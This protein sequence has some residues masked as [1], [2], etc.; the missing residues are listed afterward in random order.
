MSDSYHDMEKDSGFSE[1]QLQRVKN[2][3]D[4]D[5]STIDLAIL[6]ASEAEYMK[7]SKMIGIVMSKISTV[8]VPD[9]FISERVRRLVAL[10]QLE[11][12][13][14]LYRMRYCEIRRARG[15]K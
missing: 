15:G 7:L 8:S 13:G 3:T 14:D 12:R 11:S 4:S 10:G 5:I 9:I 1:D 2:L 6:H